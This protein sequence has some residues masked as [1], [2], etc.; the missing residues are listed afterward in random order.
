MRLILTIILIGL[1]KA[2]AQIVINASAP[3]RPLL[4]GVLLDDYPNAA[5]A[6]SLRKLRTG[7]TGAAIR[8]RRDSTGQTEADIGF[9]GNDLDTV[10]LKDFIR[11]NNGFVVRWYNQS[12][13]ATNRNAIQA[14]AARQPR[15]INAGVIERENGDVCLRWLNGSSHHLTVSRDSLDIGQPISTFSVSKLTAAS[16]INASILF[17][18]NSATNTPFR[19]YASG[20][21]E[22]PN[23]RFMLYTNNVGFLTNCGAQN[24]NQ[25]LFYTLSQTATTPNNE[26]R[27]NGTKVDNNTGTVTNRLN[28]LTIGNIRPGSGAGNLAIY[29]WSGWIFELVIY[30]A[31]QSSNRAGIETNINTYYSIY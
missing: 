31:N 11:N 7:Y 19:L 23:N 10:A 12:G 5:V 21:N 1:L 17:D 26:V 28:G 13:S 27:L 30:D 3:Y 24:A 14:T 22:A 8:V 9:V 15:I 2:D 29:D 16:G 20:N 25:N 6:Y 4:T 18:N